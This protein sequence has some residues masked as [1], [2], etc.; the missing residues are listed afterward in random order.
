MSVGCKYAGVTM[1]EIQKDVTAGLGFC[2]LLLLLA[3]IFAEIIHLA[4]LAP[5]LETVLAFAPGG[6]AEMTVLALVVGADMA[7]VVAHHVLRIFIV[8][9]GAPLFARLFGPKSGDE[10]S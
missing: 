6:Q 5:P 1:A 3:M 7:F 8:I 9:L 4:G 10:K 2:V